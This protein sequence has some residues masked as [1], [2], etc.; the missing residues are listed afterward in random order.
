MKDLKSLNIDLLDSISNT[1]KG[2]SNLQ[3]TES[4]RV[5]SDATIGQHI[6]HILEFYQAIDRAISSKEVNYDDRKRD[7]LIETNVETARNV[8]FDSIKKINSYPNDLSFEMKGNYSVNNIDASTIK[9][10]LM[11][12]L[13]YAM[14]HTIHHLAIIKNALQLQGVLLDE[15]FG[16]APSTVRYR[17]E[18]CAQ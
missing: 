4:M 10:S 3:Y 2:L 12:E 1:I 11:R 18:L 8:I 16:V 14:D 5:L 9:T 7:I 13:A 6:R 15:N 17:K